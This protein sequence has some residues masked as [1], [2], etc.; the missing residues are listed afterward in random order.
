M[1]DK[2]C[3]SII[4]MINSSETLCC[5]VKDKHQTLE[6]IEMGSIE[7]VGFMVEL[8]KKYGIEFDDEEIAVPMDTSIMDLA[9]MVSNKLTA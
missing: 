9:E 5:S 1:K 2:I 7:F 3:N 6:E 8:E 4:E